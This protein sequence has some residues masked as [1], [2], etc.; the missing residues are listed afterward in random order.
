MS[1]RRLP[2]NKKK[3][4]RFSKKNTMKWCVFLPQ[5]GV[6]ESWLLERQTQ[7]PSV[8]RAWFKCHLPSDTDSSHGTDATAISLEQIWHLARI[9]EGQKETTY[10]NLNRAKKL[11]T[12]Q[13]QQMARASWNKSRR[14][15][16]KEMHKLADWQKEDPFLLLLQLVLPGSPQWVVLRAL[17]KS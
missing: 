5:Q 2:W 3:S 6:Q 17:L 7:Y 13:K 4:R 14:P 1:G 9:K 16:T 10:Y 11:F 8:V 12:R 15:A